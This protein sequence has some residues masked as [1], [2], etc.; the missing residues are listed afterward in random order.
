MPETVRANPYIGPTSFT[1]N[2]SDRFFGRTEET[3]ELS[4]LVIARR[5]VLLY[6][7][8]GSGKTSL[9]QAALIP[10]L[11]RRKRVETFAISRVTGSADTS[12][13]VYV[14]NA[15]SHLFPDAPAGSL[16]GKTFSEAFGA[17]LWSDAKSR[18]QPHLLIFDQFE[19]IFTYH[20]ELTEQREAFFAQLGECLSL[21]HI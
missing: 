8:S 12:G 19:E 17:V 21:I 4:S 16:R 5:A 9:L 11:K 14:E 7:Q 6:A 15:L 1:E 18:R 20:P 2:D 10:E 13:N 3:R